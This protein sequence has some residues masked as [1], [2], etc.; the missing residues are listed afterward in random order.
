MSIPTIDTRKAWL[1]E[2]QLL[3]ERGL[4]KITEK[5][6]HGKHISPAEQQY[7]KICGAFLYLYKL[8]E[9]NQILQADD[10]DNPFTQ[11]TVH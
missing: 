5:E 9:E 6:A 3:T 2:L 4:I 1:D 11:E 8:A 7:A 10:P